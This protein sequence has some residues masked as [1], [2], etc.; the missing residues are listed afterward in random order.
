MANNLVKT[1]EKG[2]DQVL[3]VELD[4]NPTSSVL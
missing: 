3:W 1:I 4:P 2:Y